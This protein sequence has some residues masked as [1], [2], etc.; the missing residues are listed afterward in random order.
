M[1][2]QKRRQW[3]EK[4]IDENAQRRIKGRGGRQKLGK[5]KKKTP[6]GHSETEEYDGWQGFFSEMGH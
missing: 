4:V 6:K 3:T 2:S 1:N 5:E